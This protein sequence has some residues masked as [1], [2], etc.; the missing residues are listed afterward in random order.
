MIGESVHEIGSCASQLARKE[1][2]LLRVTDAPHPRHTQKVVFFRSQ[3]LLVP[4]PCHEGDTRASV[5]ASVIGSHVF[6]LGLV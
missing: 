6:G 2:H 1:D 5:R 4:V 3:F